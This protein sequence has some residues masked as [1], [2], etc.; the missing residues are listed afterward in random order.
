MV[1]SN[2]EASY[3]LHTD[4]RTMVGAR[5]H[6]HGRQHMRLE[7]LDSAMGNEK[8]VCVKVQQQR[9]LLRT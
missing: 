5:L 9:T 2:T 3:G 8:I 7:N 4:T 1:V 6:M